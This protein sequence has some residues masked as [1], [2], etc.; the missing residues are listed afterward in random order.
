MLPLHFRSWSLTPRPDADPPLPAQRGA[1]H[2]L[3][4][5]NVLQAS[6]SAHPTK[7]PQPGA[8]KI[9]DPHL[10]KSP[11]LRPPFKV[12]PGEEDN[13]CPHFNKKE[14]AVATFFYPRP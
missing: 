2:P 14:L 4:N 1:S 3:C 13:L 8:K 6:A 10:R 7:T 12:H 11:T 9:L 5:T